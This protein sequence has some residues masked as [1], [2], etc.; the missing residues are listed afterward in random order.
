MENESKPRRADLRDFLKEPNKNKYWYMLAVYFF[1]VSPLIQGTLKTINAVHNGHSAVKQL[2]T[3]P[4]SDH[5]D[6]S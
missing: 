6:P 1:L 4:D 3:K 5:N 2:L